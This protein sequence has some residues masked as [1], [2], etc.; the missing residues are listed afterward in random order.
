MNTISQIVK[1]SPGYKSAVNVE[2]DIDNYEKVSS[3]IPTEVG[4]RCLVSVARALN[5]ECKER[6]FLITGTYG[7]GKSH[8][9]LILCHFLKNTGINVHLNPVMEK[10]KNKWLDRYEEINKYR[11]IEDKPF[12]LVTLYQDEGS[13]NDALLRKLDATLSSLGLHDLLPDTVFA[14]ALKRIENIK[15]KHPDALKD[16]KKAID[17]EG[18]ISIEDLERRLK[19]YEKEAFEIFLTLHPRFSHG[20]KFNFHQD[21]KAS[22]VFASVAK[23]LKERGL[24][25]IVV[26]WDEFGRYLEQS[27]EDPKGN[28]S[29]ELQEFAEACND[30]YLH[31]E[32]IKLF[33]FL[34][35]HREMQEYLGL[36]NARITH[37][38]SE[39]EKAASRSDIQKIQKRFHSEIRMKA[40]DTEIFDL[41][42]QVTVQ[43]K[44]NPLWGNIKNKGVFNI[45]AE[46]CVDARLFAFDK[47]TILETVVEGAYPL[48]PVTTC[49][50]PK[51]SEKVAQNE[52]TLFQ[53]LCK[54]EPKSVSEFIKK[55]IEEANGKLNVITPDLLLDYFIEEA[56]RSDK[57]KTVTKEYINAE[58]L[59]VSSPN[60]QKKI[61]KTIAVL[62]MVSS[63]DGIK[64]PATPEFIAF[65]LDERLETI[66]DA[67]E[68]MS[69][70][71]N[72]E[73]ILVRSSVD[74]SYRFYGAGVIDIEDEIGKLINERATIVSPVKLLDRT[75]SAGTDNLW[76]KIGLPV[77]IEPKSYN[78][79]LRMNRMIEI[80]PIDLKGIEGFKGIENDGMQDGLLLTVLCESELEIKKAS[81]LV[82][83]DKL[84]DSRI[85]TAIPKIP[86]NFSYFVRKY[87]ALNRLQQERKDIFGPGAPYEGEW[88]NEFEDCLE[89]LKKALIPLM[90]PE[91]SMLE[92]YVSGE[93]K[94][95][96]SS[97]T[98]LENM[99]TEMMRESFPSTPLVLREELKKTD[100]N[101][102]FKK[103]RKP[104]IDNIFREDGPEA[105]AKEVNA[106]VKSVI[107]AILKANNILVKRQGTWILEKPSDNPNMARVWSAIEDFTLSCNMPGKPVSQLIQLLLS[108]P[109]GIRK[110]SIP[111]ILACPL[112]KYILRGNLTIKERELPFN[113]ID[114][115][116]I[117]AVVSNPERYTLIYAEVGERQRAIVDG[118]CKVF[119]IE[120][121]GELGEKIIFLREKMVSWWQG[122]P[123]YARKTTDISEE[124][125]KIREQ[126]VIPLAT[127]GSDAKLIIFERLPESFGLDNIGAM[128]YETLFKQIRD[129][130]KPIRQEFE[131]AAIKL[132]D[133]ILDVFKEVFGGNKGDD[134]I[135]SVTKWHKELCEKGD[136]IANGDAGRLLEACRLLKEKKDENVLVDIASQIT[137][138][139]PENWHSSTIVGELKGQLKNIKKTIEEKPTSP[140]LE[141]DYI[142]VTLVID[143]N[144]VKKHFKKAASISQNGESMANMINEAIK[145]LGRAL[146]PEEKLTILLDVLKEHLK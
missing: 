73:R 113:K 124:A 141:K 46:K 24:A 123:N 143:G 47:E 125:K 88:T 30:S 80:K 45:W 145:G 59:L 50:L 119:E 40:N 107:D 130:I 3:Y 132:N 11:N 117:E 10:I 92:F 135:K 101:D 55:P 128:S 68:S 89:L 110:R 2:N 42:D 17:E 108:P 131:K 4:A 97:Q 64:L 86:V 115:E 12:V 138:S 144:T 8:L 7:T 33:T 98:R 6:S 121:S 99:A 58:R 74:G 90:N 139:K 27:L 104:V 15:L 78:D 1:L 103:H 23:K 79:N 81:E 62:N 66:S 95:G 76:D 52:R 94:K 25:G 114:S 9:A 14:A 43:Q 26:L 82:N 93:L 49:C 35:A 106:P 126:I 112:R 127:D 146:S 140:I 71:N 54:N 120:P 87:D 38:R 21:M 19:N 34:I 29:L 20:A 16:L 129:N 83:G 75:E 85:L 67:L 32:G 61:A 39:E 13:I 116:V 28:E 18:L 44:D 133:R 136:L 70:K 69:S 118:M 100:G 72:G 84:K 63:D 5:P 48:H 36:V 60:I 22:K 56:K 109:F 111:V 134:P 77:S 57:T 96:I 51:L 105:L 65:S 142:S 37:W 122:L 137:G 102:T 91:K 31:Q 41:I 53:F